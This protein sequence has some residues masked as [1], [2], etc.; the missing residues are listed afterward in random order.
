MM[1]DLHSKSFKQCDQLTP[2]TRTPTWQKQATRIR[3]DATKRCS[4]AMKPS[5]MFGWESEQSSRNP[6]HSR[7][8][9]HFGMLPGLHAAVGCCGLD[10]TTKLVFLLPFLIL[11]R[12]LPRRTRT[13]RILSDL[14]LLHSRCAGL[15]CATLVV[16]EENRTDLARCP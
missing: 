9:S 3:S 4:E 15:E 13:G 8:W 14:G 16:L 11:A 10:F 5:I 12:I 1:T 2:E 7:I 6:L